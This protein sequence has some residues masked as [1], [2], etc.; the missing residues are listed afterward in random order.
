MYEQ[1]QIKIH[2]KR[3][4]PILLNLGWI[5][6]HPEMRIKTLTQ[7]TLIFSMRIFAKFISG[8]KRIFSGV[9][10]PKLK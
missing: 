6:N 7:I 4:P 1:K 8:N 2:W 9:G 10:V 3:N 5:P